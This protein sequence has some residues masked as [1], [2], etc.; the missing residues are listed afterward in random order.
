MISICKTVKHFL[1]SKLLC[2]YIIFNYSQTCDHTRDTK[3]VD[4]VDRWSLFR[5]AFL[6]QTLKMGPKIVVG[7]W[8]F[9]WRWLLA[10]VRLNSK[11]G[12]A[13][14]RPAGRMRPFNLFLR[15]SNLFF[16]YKNSNLPK[17]FI[18]IRNKN[19]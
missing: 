3:I 5:G 12:M 10:Q 15:P 6:L 18:S 14:V 11:S 9:F 13:K 7:R 8:S 2:C 19:D 17:Y 16:F 4:V 1:K